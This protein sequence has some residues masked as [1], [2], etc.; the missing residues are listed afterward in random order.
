MS[1]L[2][3]SEEYKKNAQEIVLTYK[4]FSVL[5]KRLNRAE[6]ATSKLCAN[7]W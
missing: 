6:P 7:T 1:H 3:L 4:T 5:S 2:I